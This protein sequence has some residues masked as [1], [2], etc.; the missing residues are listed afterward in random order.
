MTGALDHSGQDC[1]NKWKAYLELHK[2]SLY[3]SNQFVARATDDQR[4]EHVVTWIVALETLLLRYLVLLQAFLEVNA[5]DDDPGT[6]FSSDLA[7]KWLEACSKEFSRTSM[8]SPSSLTADMDQ[9]LPFHLMVSLQQIT[10]K[11]MRSCGR[12]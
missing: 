9:A 8:E 3:R 11:F 7:L 2:S 5:N 1:L 4:W 10:L 12:Q 6:P